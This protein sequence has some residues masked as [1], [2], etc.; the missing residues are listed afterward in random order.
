MTLDSSASAMNSDSH[1][2]CATVF[3]V[4]L[5]VCH[6]PPLLEPLGS[7]HTHNSSV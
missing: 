6:T 1:E 7:P 2:L 5:T 3:L 4:V